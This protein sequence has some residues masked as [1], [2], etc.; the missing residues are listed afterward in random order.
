M[1]KNI[2]LA[3]DAYDDLAA[4]KREG[5]SFSQLARRLRQEKGQDRILELAGAWRDMTDEE[6]TGM[7]RRIHAGRDQNMGLRE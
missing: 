2:S 4:L 7:I 3:D 5:E 6:A 1:T